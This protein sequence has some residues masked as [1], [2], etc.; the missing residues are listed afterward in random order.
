MKNIL[1]LLIFLGVLIGPLQAQRLVE[2]GKGYSST[3]VN[4][5]VFR[6]SSLATLGDKQYIAY[7]DA[8]GWMVI[9]SRLLK[10]DE[11]TL[12]RTQ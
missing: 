3:S 5:T 6:N 1:S 10:S 9:G 8:D 12:N 4:T 7:Y 11:W 2:V